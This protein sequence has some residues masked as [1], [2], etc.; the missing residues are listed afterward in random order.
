MRQLERRAISKLLFSW[1]R[2]MMK[3][4]QIYVV[5]DQKGDYTAV[6]YVN[7]VRVLS[8]LREIDADDIKGLGHRNYNEMNKAFKKRYKKVIKD[9]YLI[10]FD[11]KDVIKNEVRD[12][13]DYSRYI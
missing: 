1:N 10:S 13:S 4:D 6:I 9:I 5:Q 7:D 11:I 12:N 8:S 3:D 2:Q